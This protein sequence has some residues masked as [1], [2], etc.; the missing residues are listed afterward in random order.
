M[1]IISVG[2]ESNLI[3]TQKIFNTLA[4]LSARGEEA[5]IPLHL[6]L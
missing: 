3:R 6:C 5:E 2:I 1:D 4:R